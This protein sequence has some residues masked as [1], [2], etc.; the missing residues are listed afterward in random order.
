MKKSIFSLA[1]VAVLALASCVRPQYPAVIGGYTP[2]PQNSGSPFGETYEMPAAE[3]DTD[4]SFGATGIASG[5]KM[6]M[7]VL[8]SAALSNAQGLVRQKMQHAYKGAIDDYM[9][10]MGN[11]VGSDAVN[12]MERGGTQ[13]M[14]LIVNDTKATKVVFSSPDDKG[15]VTCFVGIRVDK[16]KIAE[17]ITNYISEDEELKIRFKEEEFR[18]KMDENFAKYKEK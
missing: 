4:E 2:N 11:N 17:T 5:P 14:D 7:D 15:N 12:K 10:Y 13:I 16:K 8:Q 6:R 1:L 18:K 3:Y 9:S